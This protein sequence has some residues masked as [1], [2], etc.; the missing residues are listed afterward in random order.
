MFM[1]TAVT[2]QVDPTV[3]TTRPGS[4]SWPAPIPVDA[5]REGGR[6]V[7]ALD[8]PGIPA[9]AVDVE[10]TGRLVTVRAERRPAQLGQGARVE[11]S[12]R[13]HGVFARRIEL[14]D[15]LDPGR[16]QAALGDGVL[17]LTVPV[18]Q[19]A[20]PRRITVQGSAGTQPRPKQDATAPAAA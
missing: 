4:V 11:A 20:K 5:W 13:R 10:V 2:R 17:T 18:K 6:F 15:T 1:R 8:L 7:I 19:V 9:E 3:R 12:E 16:L 14:A